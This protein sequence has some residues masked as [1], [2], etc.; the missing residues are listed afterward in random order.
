MAK[1]KK[2]AEVKYGIEITKPHSQEMYDHNDMVAAE[3]KAN[4]LN[5][6]KEL[7]TILEEADRFIMH[8]EWTEEHIKNDYGLPEIV[9]LQR[10]VC[11]S[12]YGDGYTFED[13][14]K[15][16]RNELDMMQNYA[17][18]QE[19]SYGCF[20]G[21]LPRTSFMMLGHSN[22]KFDYHVKDAEGKTS[23]ACYESIPCSKELDEE[24]HRESEG[25]I[26]SEFAEEGLTK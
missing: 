19:Y 26:W 4:I 8:R 2:P 5:K 17:I 3:M 24:W 20:E 15:E 16:F 11:F 18:H 25:G 7:L 10:L 12:G 23:P 1:A 13:V 21:L 14:D 9:K 6:W 22:E